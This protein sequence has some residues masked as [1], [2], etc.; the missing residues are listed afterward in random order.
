MATIYLLKWNN[1]YNRQLKKLQTI[2]ISSFP[3]DAILATVQNVN[4]KWIDGVALDIVI[5]YDAQFGTSPDYCLVDDDNSKSVWFIL[6][7]NRLRNGQFKFSLYRDLLNTY[8]DDII[9]APCFIEKATLSSD[10]DLIFNSENMTYNQIKQWEKPILD[11]SGFAWIIGYLAPSK[12]TDLPITGS[13]SIQND[14]NVTYNYDHTAWTYY[15]DKTVL[16]NNWWISIY[17]TNGAPVFPTVQS[18]W[19]NQ[20]GNVD[21]YTENPYTSHNLYASLYASD[22]NPS[23]FNLSTLTSRIAACV[24]ANL[25]SYYDTLKSYDGTVISF[26]DGAYKLRLR[27]KNENVETK[28]SDISVNDTNYTSLYTY[29]NNLMNSQGYTHSERPTYPVGFEASTTVYYFEFEKQELQGSYSYTIPTSTRQ[30]SDAEFKM[31]GI[32]CKTT[33]STAQYLKGTETFLLDMNEA[34]AWA[35]DV[36]KQADLGAGIYDLQIL[37]YSFLGTEGISYIHYTNRDVINHGSYGTLNTDYVYLQKGTGS[38][39]TN[40]CVMFFAKKSTF[41]KTNLNV[42]NVNVKYKNSTEFKIAN[43]CDFYRLTSP[44]FNSIFEIKATKNNG[45]SN[46]SAECTYKPYTPFIC[47]HPKFDRLYGK[48]YNDNMGLIL[49]GDFSLPISKDA[50]VG[51]QIQNKY[52]QD[53]FDRGIQNMNINNSIALTQ[54]NWQTAAGTVSGIAGGAAAGAITGGGIGALAGGAIGGAS[55]LAGGIVDYQMLQ[56][57]QAETLDYKKDMFGYQLGNIQAL[58]N[59]LVR[60]GSL[61]AN[62]KFWPI[63]EYFT[64][65]DTEKEALRNKLKY[66]GMTVMAIGKI[67]DYITTN[68]SYIKGKII[69]F[70]NMDIDFHEAN[71]IAEEINK[72]VFI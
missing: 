59:T 43:E 49:S 38:D 10:N 62:N 16:N 61:T 35:M 54:A 67:E 42:A 14:K 45:L 33:K 2:D 57:A 64:C 17:T 27:V 46:F 47:V 44:N 36:A 52:Y 15:G 65:T 8:Y 3:S 53:I 19:M 60:S 6:E 13:F 4:F 26:T 12:S 63:L 9:K 37:P 7:G 23:W 34:M 18:F 56:K 20:N 30:C 31:F 69:R 70:E 41:T 39:K 66:N 29:I 50:W 68:E 28:V 24:N 21:T 55:A 1:Y 48:D 58:P 51:Y 5:N 25:P 32:P 22:I 40:C 71:I 11:E 72:G